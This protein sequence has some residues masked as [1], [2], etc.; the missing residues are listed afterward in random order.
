MVGKPNQLI[1]KATFQSV[2]VFKE[3]FSRILTD[4]VDSLPKN[5]AGNE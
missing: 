3:L 5:K 4:C 2:P 1:H